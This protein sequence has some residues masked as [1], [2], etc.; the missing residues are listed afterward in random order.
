MN[1]FEEFKATNDENSRKHD[2]VLDDKVPTAVVGATLMILINLGR[3]T[4]IHRPT[5]EE[6]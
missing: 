6:R 1:A 5:L 2:A 4:T 3:V